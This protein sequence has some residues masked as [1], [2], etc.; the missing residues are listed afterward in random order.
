MRQPEIPRLISTVQ[1]ERLLLRWDV[2]GNRPF[3]LPVDVRVGDRTHRVAMDGGNGTLPIRP[4]QEIEI[5]P[6]HWILM[7]RD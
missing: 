4:D 2:P 7:G 3:P 6:E 5:D 1:G